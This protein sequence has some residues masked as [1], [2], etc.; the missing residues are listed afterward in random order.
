MGSQ[1]A[2]VSLPVALGYFKMTAVLSRSW[3]TQT[4]QS[5]F[6]GTKFIEPLKLTI[7]LIKQKSKLSQRSTANADEAT[8]A[9]QS[10]KKERRD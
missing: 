6:G 7:K 3:I 2:A 9:K 10:K 5:S 1:P 8:V 4:S